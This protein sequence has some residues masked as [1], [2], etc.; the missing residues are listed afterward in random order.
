MDCLHD[1]DRR[2]SGPW[3][4]I[5]INTPHRGNMLPGFR[6]VDVTLA[7]ELITLLTMLTSPL[8]VALTGDH[9]AAGTLPAEIP[10][11][12]EDVQHRENILH[13]FGVMLDS[14]GMQPNRSL[15]LTQP[16]SGLFHC[17]GWNTRN[18][19]HL[20][21]MERFHTLRHL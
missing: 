20:P 5:R 12:Q 18:F 7:W 15:S 4:L 21:R 19:G 14:S 2:V 3:D 11:G 1:L 10:R 13:T 16:F 17:F 9:H 6:V 8:A